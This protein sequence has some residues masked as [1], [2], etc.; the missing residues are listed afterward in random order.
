MMKEGT[1]LN[2]KFIKVITW[3]A[4][5]GMVGGVIATIIAPIIGY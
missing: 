5:I 4:L 1:I 3:L 2:K